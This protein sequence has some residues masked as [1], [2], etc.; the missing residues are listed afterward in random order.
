MA[1]FH[2]DQEVVFKSKQGRKFKATVAD[3]RI[4]GGK[5]KLVVAGD[6]FPVA[7]AVAQVDDCKSLSTDATVNIVTNRTKEG[8][9][10]ATATVKP[11]LARRLAKEAKMQGIKGYAKMSV[12]ELKT[13]VEAAR[14]GNGNGNGAKPAAK[15]SK[16]VSKPAKA[17]ARP[18]AAKKPAAKPAKAVATKKAASKPVK[19]ATKPAKAAPVKAQRTAT[20]D[21]PFREGSNSFLMAAELLKGGNRGQMVKRLKKAMKIHPWSKDKEENP[22]FAIRKRLLLVAAALEKDYGFTIEREGRGEA[23]SMIAIPPGKKGG[24]KAKAQ[25]SSSA[26]KATK[27]R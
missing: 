4:R 22:E 6:P 16:S 1:R 7:V 24:Q 5:V 8:A 3:P 27:K 20:G 21:N 18:S 17:T 14:N 2:T 12:E 10:M 25:A 26:K 23:G 9:L 13:A 11:N 15:A 19:K